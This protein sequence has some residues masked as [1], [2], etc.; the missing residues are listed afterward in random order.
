MGSLGGIFTRYS[1]TRT[2]DKTVNSAD[3][4]TVCLVGASI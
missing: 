4:M 3:D 2:L 1:L